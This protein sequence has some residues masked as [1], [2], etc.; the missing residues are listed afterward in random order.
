[1]EII[2]C[3]EC[4]AR[5]IPEL[6]FCPKCGADAGI[7]IPTDVRCECGFL[8]CKLSE[9]A[10][11]VKCRRCKRLVYVPIDDV[12][13]RFERN[14]KMEE[15]RSQFV[16][17]SSHPREP[18]PAGDHKGQYCSVCGKYKPNVVYGK[19]LD[20]RTESIKIQYRTRTR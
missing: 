4:G 6:P 8:L 17:R 7:E 20:C 9:D 16:P 1:M 15:K 12:P 18:R 13:A 11:E 19:C 14:K 5:L 2:E 10:I 3:K